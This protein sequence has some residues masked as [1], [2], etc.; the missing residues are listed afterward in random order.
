MNLYYLS[1]VVNRGQ[2]LMIF[3]TFYLTMV[4]TYLKLKEV[5]L[6]SIKRGIKFEVG[7]QEARQLTTML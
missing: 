2:V 5:N 7:A 1:A 3:L 6:V 4:S